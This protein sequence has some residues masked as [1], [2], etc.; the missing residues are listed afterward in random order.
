MD[1]LWQ[2]KGKIVLIQFPFEDLSSSKVRPAYCLT[3][4]VGVYQHI[5]FALITSRI[6][7]SPLHTDIILRPENPDFMMSGLRKSSTIR[8]DHLVTLRASLIQREL[9]LLS[10]KTRTLIVNILYDI[11]R[12]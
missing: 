1:N 9:G 7:E 8:L 10:L 3:N 2:M 12:S 4:K 5:I 6:P 11:L